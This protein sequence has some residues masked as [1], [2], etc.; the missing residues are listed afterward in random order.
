MKIS[1]CIPTYNQAA[2]IGLTIRSVM[3]QTLLPDEIIVSDDCSTDNT[4]EILEKL[5]AE[6]SMLTIIRQQTNQGI[7]GNT[8]ACLRAA[9]GEYIVKL[10]SDDALL[11][12]YIK[13]LS[14][15]L[16]EHPEAG[17]AHAAV[18][19][20]DHNGHAGEPRRLLRG[21]GFVSSE[22]ALKSAL[23][24][25]R[26]AAN[27]LM[28]RKEALEKVD[29]IQCT[30]DFAED[31]FLSVCIAKAG[32]G[33]V[34]SPKILSAY[35]VW[36]DQGNVR[37]RRKLAEIN[38]LNAVLSNAITPAFEQRAWDLTPVLR[39]KQHFAI[40]H[41]GCLSWD[42][43]NQ[44]EKRELENA[45]LRLSSAPTTKFYIWSHKNG[46]GKVLELYQNSAA[47]IKRQIKKLILTRPQ[48][49]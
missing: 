22:D 45:I 43:Y 16:T 44:E 17:Y 1:V 4:L 21:A 40:T 32:Y 35:R 49:R 46:F 19:E 14:A 7:A 31:Y 27:I 25:Y 29:Y 39:A 36:T 2:Y 48:T 34:Y 9:T 13:T 47:T 15:L 37:K 24:G 26:V 5:A 10:D 8:D 12:D 28:F 18:R 6:I 42:V 38:G 3:V 33:N 20:I 41:S 23:K 30:Q 11:P